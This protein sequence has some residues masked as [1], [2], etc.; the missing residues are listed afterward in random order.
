M[1]DV[2]Q[3][4][5]DGAATSTS[6]SAAG[7]CATAG[8]A[9]GWPAPDEWEEFAADER[10]AAAARRPRQ[11]GRVPHRS[12]RRD[13]RHVVP[14]LRP[15]DAAVVDLLG[16]QPPLRRARSARLRLV[17]GRDRAVRGRRHVRGPADPACASPGRAS[18]RRSRAGSRPSRPTAGETWETN[19]IMDFTPRGGR[20]MSPLDAAG[21]I[22]PATSTSPRSCSR[23]PR[24]GWPA[25]C[26]SGTRSPRGRGRSP[27]RSPTLAREAARRDAG[28]VARGRAR[29]RHPAPLRRELLLPAG[30]DLAQRERALGDGLGQGRASTSRPS[31]PWP[32][33]G[34]GTTRRSASGSCARSATSRAPGAATCARRATPAPRSTTST[35]PT[36]A[37][38]ELR[39][40]RPRGRPAG[41]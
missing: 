5:G 19:W 23:A 37:R 10:R 35:T 13:D 40:L 34:R 18:T 36:R 9:S 27:P 26:S 41:N 21:A 7:A 11:R 8:C 24:R 16:R 22:A 2:M 6:C 14:L 38:P 28:R 29:L 4:V 12:R 15:E 32:L 30:H 20:A 31:R 3:A 39:C 17:R 33:D 25:G 1:H